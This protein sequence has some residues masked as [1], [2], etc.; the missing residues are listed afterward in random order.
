MSTHLRRDVLPVEGAADPVSGRLPI[1]RGIARPGFDAAVAPYPDMARN[2]DYGRPPT[3]LPYTTQDSYTRERTP[4]ELPSL[5][6]EN[7]VLTATFLPD[8]GGRLWS[9][10]HR[11]TGRELLHRNPILQPANLALRDAWLAGGVEWNIGG[12]GHW[13]LTCSPLHAVRLNAPDGTPVLRMYEFERMRRVVMTVDAWLPEGSPALMVHVSLHNPAETPTPVYWWSNIAVPQGP[14]VR[15]VA[16]AKRAFHF[17]YTAQLKLIDF[18]QNAATDTAAAT[19]ADSAADQS[20]PARFP[21]AADFF[22]D[23][24]SDERRWIAA[25]DTN[26]SGLVQTSTDRLIG[27]KLFQWGVGA[28]GQRWQEWLSG[29]D[30]EYIEIQAGLARTQLEHLELPGGATWEWVEAYGLLEAD[31]ALVHGTWDESRSAVSDALEKLIPCASLDAALAATPHFTS[32]T[33]DS[34]HRGSGWGALEIASGA[35]PGDALRPFGSC[36]AEQQPWLEL[37]QT[38]RLPA[39]EPPASPI[40]GPLWR[41]LLEASAD[42][43]HAL[44]HLGLIRLADDDRDGA[45]E[46]WTRSLADRPNAWAQRALAHL[47]DT[48]DEAATLTLAAHHLLPDLRELTIE[49]LKALL[50]ADRPTDALEV[51]STLPPEHRNHGRIRLYNAEA[52]LATG[53]IDQVRRL[54][55][56]GITVDNLQEGEASLDLLWLAAHPDQPVPPH[57]DFRMSGS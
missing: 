7:E 3:L 47:A 27:R 28:G 1:L 43:W 39:S 10:V 32:P 8:Y 55:D 37:L 13:P 20:Y 40:T 54:L 30:A 19:D 41:T 51:I 33:P 44:Y 15:V 49:T 23:I 50:T 21:A 31:A 2:L 5:V 42:D 29:P 16:P 4:R 35:L 22:M 17:D 34:L 46:A 24:P 6:L 56:E 12:T 48:P 18:P 57:Y 45:R 53:D 36:D 25:L 52:A 9:L 11:P 14:D 26:G 38:R